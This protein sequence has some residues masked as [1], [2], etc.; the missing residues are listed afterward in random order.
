MPKEVN[1]P[2]GQIIVGC[3]S[4]SIGKL[5]IFLQFL[6]FISFG[7]INKVRRGPKQKRASIFYDVILLF[8]SVQR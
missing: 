6:E 1:T 8:E 5:I 2:T 3:V 4:L 7:N